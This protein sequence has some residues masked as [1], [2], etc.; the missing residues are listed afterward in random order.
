MS[1]LSFYNR[2]PRWVQT[3][4]LSAQSWRYQRQRRGG[5]YG[6]L[7]DQL[8]R[9]QWWSADRIAS[10]RLKRFGDVFGAAAKNVP[11]YKKI[12]RD[13]GFDPTAL[14]RFEELQTLPMIT[15]EDIRSDPQSFVDPTRKII[16]V[17]KTGGTTGAPLVSPYDAE[18]MQWAY[19]LL[20][21]FYITNGVMPR[22]RSLHLTGQQVVPHHETRRFGR[23]S[24]PLNALFLSVHHVNE[25]CL[26]SYWGEILKFKPIW[27]DGYTSFVYELAQWV[28]RNNHSGEL[29][30]AGVFPT[31][32]LLTDGMRQSIETAFSTRVF[33]H[34][35]ATE[36]IPI[37]TQCA[38]GTYHIVP[39]SGVVEFLRPDGSAA[40][41]GEPAEMVMTSFR[42]LS[43]PIL[44]YRIGDTAAWS[45]RRCSCGRNWPVVE[46]LSGRLA[47]WVVNKHGKRISQ[48]SHQVF[49][50]S[51]HVSASQIIQHDPEKFEILIVRDTG[52]SDA[53]DQFIRGRLVEVLG[54]P[55]DVAIRH[56]PEIPRT[57][58]GKRPSVISKIAVQMSR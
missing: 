50:V 47:E 14:K 30:L 29:V 15:K 8:L 44:R 43:R 45:D 38:V 23:R 28:N 10:W 3:L 26:P 42:N 32:E 6:E 12:F 25:E 41:A 58:G 37:I 54:H 48:F 20:D 51:H 31:S 40:A 35:S 18:S 9:S 5:R 7:L 56:V 21:R 24:Y 34:Y 55:A 53:D 49:K 39:E 57:A 4:M 17:S 52:Y 27:V 22:F 19:A 16:Y 11:Y 46:M 1:L 2:S 33:D 36:G 13:S